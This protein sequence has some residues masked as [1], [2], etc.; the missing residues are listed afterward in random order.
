MNPSQWPRRSSLSTL[1]VFHITIAFLF[2]LSAAQN[3]YQ[4]CYAIDSSNTLVQNDTSIYQSNGR[5]GGQI[6]GPEGYAVFG[7]T[8][9]SQCWCGNSIPGDQVSGDHCSIQCPGY[10]NNT[11]GG[12]GYLSVWLTNVGKLVGNAATSI[13]PSSVSST[14]TNTAASGTVYITAGQTTITQVPTQSGQSNGGGS[15]GVSGGAAAGIAIGILA[16]MAVGVGAFFFI[17]RRRRIDYQKQ[18][19]GSNFGSSPG[20]LNRPFGTDQRLEPGMVQKRESVGSLADNQDYSRKILRVTN[21]DG[22]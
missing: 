12:V 8:G 1:L 18:W 9:G 16:L 11:C 20:S 22:S 6:C 13:L 5:C 17:R 4:G 14:A 15:S 2:T 19:E 10:P 21:P 7:M 3:T